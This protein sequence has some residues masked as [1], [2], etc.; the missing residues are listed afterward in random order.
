MSK[1]FSSRIFRIVV[2]F[3]ILAIAF[4]TFMSVNLKSYAQFGELILDSPS[5]SFS[6]D[7]LSTI[8]NDGDFDTTFGVGGKVITGFSSN[9]VDIAYQSAIQN[10]GKIVTAGGTGS[11]LALARYN[12]NGSLDMTFDDDGKVTTNIPGLFLVANTLSI[13]TD[14]KIVVAGRGNGDFAVLRYNPNGLLDTSFDGDGIVITSIMS[15]GDVAYDIAIQTDGKIIVAGYG[16]TASFAQHFAVVRYNS[17]GT[18]DTS[19]GGDGIVTTQVGTASNAYSEA[20]SV[21]LQNDGK[22]ILGGFRSGGNSTSTYDDFALVRYNADGSLDTSFDN[23]GIVTTN[24]DVNPG[25]VEKIESIFVQPNGKIVAAGHGFFGFFSDEDMA[26]ARY[27]SNG[28]LDTTFNTN[29]KVKTRLG[30]GNEYLYDIAQ[31]SDEKLVAVG[32]NKDGLDTDALVVRYTSNGALDSS[33]NGTGIVISGLGGARNEFNDVVLQND[34]KIIASGATGTLGGNMDFV[35]ARY[36]SSNPTIIDISPTL[37]A[38]NQTTNLFVNGANFQNNFVASITTP[39]GTFPIAAA[40]LTFVNSSQVR[41]QVNM[42][43]TPPYTA[44]LRIT[45]PDNQS[46]TGQFQVVSTTNLP[47]T[48]NSINPTSPTASSI[49]QN[50]IVNGINFQFGLTVTVMFPN[51]TTGTLSG[52]QIQNVTANSF[53]MRITLGNAGNWNIRV[54]NPNG[55]QSNVFGFVVQSSVQPPLI[56]SINPTAPVVGNTD[57][58]ITVSGDNFQQNSTVAITFPNGGG[59]TL[60][61]AQI[62]NIT[63]TSFV[64][65][66]TLNAAGNWTIKVI[67]PN[68]GQ[69]N[70]FGFGVSSAGNNPIINTINPTAPITNGADQNVIVS[71]SNFQNNLRVNVSFPDGGIA[72]LQGTGQIQN[73]TANSFTMRITLNATGSWTIRILNPDNSQSQQFMFGVQASGP[74]PT[75]LP[76]SVLSPVIGSLRVTTSNQGTPDGKWEF[77]QHGTGFHTPTGGISLSNDRYSWDVNLYTPTSGNA[78]A[79]KSVFAVADGQIVS[80]VGTAPGGGPGAVLIAHPNGQ[81]PVW[82]SGYLHM[83]NVRAIIG[84]AVNS[85]TIIGEIGRA[86]AT[87][88]HLHFVIYSGQ[89]TRGNL[90]SFNAAITERLANGTNPPTISTI[91]PSTVNQSNESQL[92]TINGANFQSNSIIEVQTPSGQSFTVTPETISGLADESKIINITSS[93][94]TARV[95]FTGGGTYEFSIINRP[96]SFNLNKATNSSFAVSNGNTVHSVPSGRTPVI[97]IPGIMGSRIAKRNSN[98]SFPELWLAGLFNDDEHRELANEV[99]DPSNYRPMSARNV[100]PTNIIRNV[101]INIGIT[102]VYGNLVDYLTT[103][104]NYTLYDV[105]YPTVFPC[106][107]TRTDADLFVFPYDWRNSNFTSARDLWYYVQCIKSIRGNPPNFKVDIIAHSMGGLVARR[108]ILNNPGTH[109]VERM[110]TLGTPWLG[111]P[112][113][114]G[115]MDNGVYDFWTNRAIN[116]NILKQIAPYIKGAH[117]LIPSKAYTD[118]LTTADYGSFPMGEMGWDFN[119]DQ[120]MTTRYN[121]SYLKGAM[122]VNY[123]N[124][125]NRPG[126][127]TDIFHNQPGQDRWTANN[128][129]GVNYYQFVGY[130]KNTIGTIVA[131][132]DFG[133]NLLAIA[134]TNGDGTVPLVSAT[135]IGRQDYRGPIQLEKGFPLNHGD[136]ASKRLIFPFINCV[137]NVPDANTCIN[138]TSVTLG[139]EESRGLVGDPNYL[140]KVIGSE[141]VTI[142]DSFGNTTNPL[143]T[144]ADEGVRTIDT[145]VMGNKHLNATFPLD[146][147]YKAVIKTPATPFSIIL[148]K[149][150]GQII[151]QAIRYVDITL[152]ANVLALLEITPQGV[153]NLA[154]DSDGNGTFDTP[155]NPTITVTGTQAQDIEPPNVVVNE[156]VQ[157]VASQIVLEATDAGTGVQRIMYS[158]NGTTFQQ[159][160]TPLTLNPAQIS[161]IYVFADDNV[162]NRSGL[163]THTLTTSNVGYS[164]AGPPVATPGSQIT[165]NWNA[166]NGRPVDDWVG[167]FRVGTLN[168]AY[169]SK[170]Y[171]G[172]QPTSSLSFTLPNLPGLYEFRYL[173]NDGFS[174]VAISNEINANSTRRARFD[175]DGDGKADISVFRPSNGVWYLLQSTNGFTGMNFGLGTDK[176]VPADYDGDGK[177]D[178]AVYRGGT[179]YLQ[180]SQLGFTGVAF[181]DSNDIPVPADYDGDGKAD[182]AVFRP[183]NG[184]WYLQRSQL[185]FIGIGFG[186][187]GDKPVPADYDSDGKADVA[188]NRNGVWYLQRSQLGFTG[189]AF[190]DGNDKLVPADYDGDGKA[191]IAVFRPSNGTWYLL[192]STAGFSGIAFG[193]GTDLPVPADY[194]GDGKADLAVFRNGTWYLQ[195]STQ[196]FT[197]VAFGAAD[198]KPI[199]NAFVR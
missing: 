55:G 130:G 23:D 144:S 136:L 120:R 117:E 103:D 32:R 75:G 31:Q 146:Q 140:L 187:N 101:G 19:L 52:T 163:V 6:E 112:K 184:V 27:N 57:Q 46:A 156:T 114:I 126:D 98:G 81:N 94:I 143:S 166:P 84:Q 89:N 194:D 154:Y 186:Q 100:V 25:S 34:G 160:S 87:N 78:D 2:G 67:N 151:T 65:R 189:I 96:T 26:L 38:V 20:H 115:I 174:S 172:G 44:T 62:Q 53:I 134:N 29:G 83:K 182:I 127:T 35:V 195:R 47:P 107:T 73:V 164:V 139:L 4:V 22:I 125:S 111:A 128:L 110:V 178:V 133:T 88:D 51:G 15:G 169:I 113:V 150:N 191:D 9:S 153:T 97:F 173:I 183:S 176:L 77:N 79:G 193:L 90:H 5:Q 41:V 91:N 175:F 138:N 64:M 106:D 147:N 69:S 142:S 104:K 3:F 105:Q 177:T 162:F 93:A 36:Q 157:T 188:V 124:P 72:T 54:N 12:T 33:F 99:E 168:S 109:N 39:N 148:T 131:K 152:P 48:I 40:G 11:Q 68:G 119:F 167:L 121:F 116:R 74:P 165:A 145:D 60:S 45:N 76:T 49:D 95:A 37:V 86:G 137:V 10:N 159:Y 179:W 13:Q 21:A 71:G 141:S 8:A 181:G 63:P 85:T 7:E 16:S 92:I 28:S 155:V 102:D 80:Y 199:P 170:Q 180:R 123:S 192:Q 17:D 43:G 82:Y 185:G 158:L 198:D 70:I 42:G 122:N 18:L 118:D 1:I 108:Y 161:T 149:S 58:D 171:T 14:G 129:F 135:R 61:G 50:I 24:F 59:T 30:S 132:R 190:G 56:F 66:A 196:G 197:G